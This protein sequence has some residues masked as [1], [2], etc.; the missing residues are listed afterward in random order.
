MLKEHNADYTYRDYKKDPL[1]AD[2][3]GQVLTKLGVGPREVLRARD[4]KK[5]DIATDLDDAK[6]I[7][8][9]AMH[10]GLLQRPILVDGDKAVV[11]RPVDNLLALLG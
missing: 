3:I 4:A 2:Q 10:P 5:H 1:T 9:M 6:L 11:G 8:A 7:E